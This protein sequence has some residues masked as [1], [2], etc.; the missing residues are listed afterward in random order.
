MGLGDSG[1]DI[2]AAG[3]PVSLLGVPVLLPPGAI[4]SGPRVGI[5]READRAWRFWI[6]GDPAVSTYRRGSAKGGDAAE[7]RS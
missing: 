6:A 2:L 5:S 1:A 7:G 4:R 3:A